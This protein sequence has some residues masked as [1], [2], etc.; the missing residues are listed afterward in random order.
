MER[1]ASGIAA[2]SIMIVACSASAPGRRPVTIPWC[3]IRE[4]PRDSTVSLLL[5]TRDFSE[6]QALRE[7]LTNRFGSLDSRTSSFLPHQ[8]VLCAPWLTITMPVWS[9][10]TNHVLRLAHANCS[11]RRDRMAGRRMEVSHLTWALR[12]PWVRLN[13]HSIACLHALTM[14]P[15][16]PHLVCRLLQA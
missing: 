12:Q 10:Q 15:Q 2:T 5:M 9:F 14:Y 3:V 13:P 7:T 4:G 8:L 6:C 16:V 1:I 11:Q